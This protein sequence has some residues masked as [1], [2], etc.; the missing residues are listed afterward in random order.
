[1]DLIG[2]KFAKEEN[3]KTFLHVAYTDLKMCHRFVRFSI[4]KTSNFRDVSNK[5]LE[6]MFNDYFKD[7]PGVTLFRLQ[8][9]K[10]VNFNNLSPSFDMMIQDFKSDLKILN[11][12]FDKKSYSLTILYDP[13][14]NQRMRDL[15]SNIESVKKQND[16]QNKY[17]VKSICKCFLIKDEVVNISEEDLK[18]SQIEEIM[19]SWVYDFKIHFS[20]LLDSKEE[21]ARFIELRPNCFYI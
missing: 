19:S 18:N 1:M 7:D 14:K 2:D 16:V 17:V 15:K 9:D 13:F 8:D 6:I 5:D 21:D 10:E 12:H 4:S 3:L 20:K 11:M